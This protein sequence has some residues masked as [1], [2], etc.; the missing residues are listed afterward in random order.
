MIGLFAAA[1]I[2]ITLI[3]GTVSILYVFQRIYLET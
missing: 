2:A 3:S 1:A